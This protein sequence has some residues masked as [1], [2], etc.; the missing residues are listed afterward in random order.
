MMDMRR[1]KTDIGKSL[2]EFFNSRAEPFYKTD[3]TKLEGL[4]MNSK[5]ATEWLELYEIFSNGP[6]LRRIKMKNN[7]IYEV[8]KPESKEE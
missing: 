8:I 3:L 6:K 2:V 7:I 1:N 4:G 5:T